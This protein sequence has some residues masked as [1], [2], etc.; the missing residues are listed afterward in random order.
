[1]TYALVNI[2]AIALVWVGATRVDGGI[3]LQG[4]VVALYS[5]L[6]IILVELVKLANLIFTVSKAISC[7][8]RIEAVL[9]REGEPATLALRTSRSPITAAARP[10]CTISPSAHGAARRWA[11]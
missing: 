10:R 1:M 4:D 11:F 2:A 5:Y 3:L 7:E 6:S 9:E 8:K